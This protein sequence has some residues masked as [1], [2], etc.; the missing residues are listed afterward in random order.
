MSRGNKRPRAMDALMAPR[1][2]AVVGASDKANVGGRIYRNM[3]GRGFSG[4]LYPVNPNYKR[5]GGQPCWADIDSLPEIPDCVAIAVPVHGVFEPLE[6]AARK[7]VRAAVVMAEGFND[8]G[9]PE[10]RAR[11]ARLKKLAVKYDMAISGPNSM[12]IVSLNRNFATAFTN[13]P[14]GL[15][16]GAVSV[17]SQSGGLLNAT[18]ELGHNRSIGFNHLISAGNEA[19]VNSADYI[20]WLA[21][22]SKTKVIINIVEGVVDG[23]RYAAALRYA[24]TKKPVVVLKLGRTDAG[25]RAA[26]AHTGSLSGDQA[27]WDAMMETTGAISVE[28]VDQL[29]ETANLFSKLKPPKGDRVFI[30]SVSGGATVLAGDLARKAGLR[31]P[32]LSEKTSRALGKILGVDRKFQNPMDVVGAP[33]LV[34]DNNLTRCLDVLAKDKSFD[35]IALVMVVQRDTSASHKILHEQFH[36]KTPTIKKPV[37]M[38]SEMAWT[39]ALRP[40]PGGPAVAATLDDGL[41]AIRHLVDYG[42]HKKPKAPARARRTIDLNLVQSGPLTEPE[43]AG[44]LAEK[45]NLPFARWEYVKTPA[46]AIKAAK[47]MGFPVALKGVARG[48]VHKTEAHGVHLDLQTGAGVKQAA[49]NIARAVKRHAP[50][51]QWEGFMVQKMIEAPAGSVEMILG[52]RFDPQFGPLLVIGAGGK[53]AELFDDSQTM[54]APITASQ[55]RAALSR[56]KVDRLL[57]GFRGSPALDRAALIKTMVNFSRFIAATEGQILEIDLNPVIVLPKMGKKSGVVI[58]DALVVPKSR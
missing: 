17:V 33:R 13:L 20:T 11:T 25:R 58:V 29:I 28:S 39:P 27:A 38:V 6:A 4:P 37:I 15:I 44:L 16:P 47:K 32:P 2:V 40:A 30:F 8:A 57:R 12:G 10:G 52:A 53:F 36:T 23:R 49:I 24:N 18:I 48:L 3:L 26:I 50:K 31:L 42:A 1:S 51:A 56:L 19:I 5:V 46:D 7:G 54:L 14:D 9:T 55:A 41:L 21:D 22:D 35:A 34:R 43:S 45:A